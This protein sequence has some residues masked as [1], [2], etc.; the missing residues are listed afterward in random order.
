MSKFI[1][2]E[3]EKYGLLTVLS[4]AE[5]KKGK[6]CWNCICDCGKKVVVRSNNLKSG[7]VQSCGCLIKKKRD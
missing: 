7:G 2:R 5:N 4:R 1:N 6:T 3:G